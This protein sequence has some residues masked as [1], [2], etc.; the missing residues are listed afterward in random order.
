MNEFKPAAYGKEELYAIRALFEGKANE[1]QQQLAM[2]WLIFNLCHIG[3]S[4][5]HESDRVTAFLEGQRS[6]GV[7]L[8]RMRE[9]EALRL[10][11]NKRGKRQTP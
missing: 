7:Q 6:V 8:A 1:G 2:A 4:S 10:I 3:Q 9:P 11:E 5:M